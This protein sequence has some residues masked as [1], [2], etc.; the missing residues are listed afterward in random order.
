MFCPVTW[1]QKYPWAPQ[2]HIVV[3]VE[4]CLQSESHLAMPQSSFAIATSDERESEISSP[5]DGCLLSHFLISQ[6]HLYS[7]TGNSHC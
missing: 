7:I 4:I 6:I 3:I 5:S 1:W 2:A